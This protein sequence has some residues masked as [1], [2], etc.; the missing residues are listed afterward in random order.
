MTNPLKSQPSESLFAQNFKACAPFANFKQLSLKLGTIEPSPEPAC[1]VVHNDMFRKCPSSNHLAPTF[2][3][4]KINGD[5]FDDFDDIVTPPPESVQHRLHRGHGNGE[6]LEKSVTTEIYCARNIVKGLGDYREAEEEERG[7]E[8]SSRR[9]RKRLHSK[10]K[11][12]GLIQEA[13]KQQMEQQERL[14]HRLRVHLVGDIDDASFSTDVKEV[15][16]SHR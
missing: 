1:E 4:G 3:I 15:S 10:Q 6:E 8:S 9:R 13:C 11:Y 16:Q 14:L 12:L 2:C 7:W 5:V